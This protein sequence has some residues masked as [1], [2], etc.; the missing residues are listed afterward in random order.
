[1]NYTY[2]LAFQKNP[3]LLQCIHQNRPI[4]IDINEKT[5][6]ITRDE[7]IYSRHS[8][9]AGKA[10]DPQQP[11]GFCVCVWNEGLSVTTS[12]S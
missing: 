8:T 12:C 10:H 6:F 11:C 7:I 5:N 1:M 4:T 2:F 9:K 3:L